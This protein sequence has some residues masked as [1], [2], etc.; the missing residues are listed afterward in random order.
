M[1][2]VQNNKEQFDSEFC[3]VTYDLERRM[4]L[5]TWK[6]FACGENYREP[7]R[8]AWEL[9]KKYPLNY[10]VVDARNSFED[11][12]EDVEWGFSIFLPGMAT[13]KCEGVYFIM[14][15]VSEIE[16]EMDMWTKEF[17]KYFQVTKVTSYEEVIRRIG[18]SK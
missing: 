3:Y 14:E 4:V 5:F 15:E 17:S 8:F 11:E 13:T 7:C 18:I 10:F 12:A 9:F 16:E 1:E 2:K 6:K